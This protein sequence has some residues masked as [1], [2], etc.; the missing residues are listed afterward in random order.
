VALT[1]DVAQMFLDAQQTATASADRIGGKA[2][3]LSRLIG[4]GARVPP[5]FVVTTEAFSSHL[6]HADLAVRVAEALATIAALDAVRDRAKLEQ[7]AAELRELIETVSLRPEVV[8]ALGNMVSAL[9][10]GPFAVRSSMVGEDGENRSFAGQ[11]DTY[12]F[13]QAADVPAA[14]V[15]CWASAFTARALVY[16]SRATEAATLPRMGVVIQRMITGRVSGVMFTSNPLNGRH[17]QVLVSA[18]WGA[19]EGVVSGRSNCDEFVSDKNGTEVS[20]T[21]ADKDLQIVRKSDGAAG[22]QEVAIPDAQ[23]RIRCLSSA[24]LLLLVQ[25]GIRLS[26]ALSGPQDIE[27]TLAEEGLYLL[28]ARPIT[29][30]ATATPASAPSPA[31]QAEANGPEVIWDNSNI[32]ESYCGVTTP[33]TFSFARR[34]YADVYEQVMRVANLPEAE[35][36]ATRPVLANLLGLL[37]GRVYYNI[38]NWYRMLQQ[39]PSFR[40]NKQDM[41]KMMGLDSPVDFVTDEPPGLLPKLRRIPRL[42]SLGVQ[43][44]RRFASMDSE[45]QLFLRNFEL[46][47]QRVASQRARFSQLSFSELMALLKQVQEELLGRWHTPIINDLYVMISSGRLRRLVERAVGTAEAA[48]LI[49]NL[50]GGEPGIESTEPTR[51]IFR[52]AALARRDAAL[53]EA[54]TKT[55]VTLPALRASHPSFAAEIEDY[56]ERYGDRCMGEL[57]LETISLREDPS[58]LLRLLRNYLDRDDLDAEAIAQKERRLRSEAEAALQRALGTFRYR[59]AGKVMAA[60]RTAVKHR[61]NMRLMRTRMFG[62]VRDLYRAIGQRL[63]A[64]GRLTQPRDVFYLSV[65]EIESYHEGT[66]VGADTA[67]L[68]AARKAEYAGYQGLTLPHRIRTRGP[69]YHGN[70]LGERTV[71]ADARGPG[72]KQLQG[73]GCYPGVV[74]AQARIILDP[75]D[76]LALSGKILVTLRTDPGWAPLFPLCRGILVERGSTLS[77]SAIL[78]RELGIPAIVGIPNLLQTVRDGELLRIDGSSGTIDRLEGK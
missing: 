77:H 76:D 72:A 59:R 43:L 11:L 48:P 15:R 20:I 51:H 2:R 60:A 39:L 22:T 62:L 32:Q 29:A 58:F 53:K 46:G 78:A 18:C 73:T 49:A 45:V 68:T 21:I 54:I 3:G 1:D 67:A 6:G 5:F 61:E 16:R 25:E 57:K 4:A 74:E 28:Q 41:E 55:S 40:R 36:A 19:G 31:D 52:M 75:S 33:L 34:A 42:A 63:A 69:V 17:D 64:V 50:M 30:M 23:R 35:I 9:G 8:S 38:N 66:A 10:S 56:I 24:E 26:T 14:L 44:M 70:P 47:Y 27:W 71:S 13:Q 12:L 7:K 65:E 37:S